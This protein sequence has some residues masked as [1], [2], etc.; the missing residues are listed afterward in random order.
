[1]RVFT[2]LLRVCA[3]ACAVLLLN[4]QSVLKSPLKSPRNDQEVEK[5]RLPAVV[6]S[7]CL[8][9]RVPRLPR[10]W[11]L[12]GGEAIQIGLTWKAD[13]FIALLSF[14]VC[15]DPVRTAVLVCLCQLFLFFPN[16]AWNFLQN[17]Q[18]LP[19]RCG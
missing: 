2:S 14:I 11:M 15:F 4:G 9:Q 19:E 18:H 1:M 10:T 5:N 8:E 6:S 16:T 12:A 13:Y 7:T 17:F 3:C